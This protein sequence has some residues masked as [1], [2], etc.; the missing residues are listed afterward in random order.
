MHV[1]ILGAEPAED[2]VDDAV[3]ELV[4]A[5]GGT[6]SAEHEVGIEK[7]RWL[8]RALGPAEVAAMRRI[9]QVLDPHNLLNPGVVLT[10]SA[11]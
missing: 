11:S 6:I 5:C 8:E 3:L 4:L 2:R 10:S 7:A 9:K 1:N